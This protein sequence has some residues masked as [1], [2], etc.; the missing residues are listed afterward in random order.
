MISRLFE[1]GAKNASLRTPCKEQETINTTISI[2]DT[3]TINDSQVIL[4]QV[5]KHIL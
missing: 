4:G 2:N 3:I 1:S 5:H